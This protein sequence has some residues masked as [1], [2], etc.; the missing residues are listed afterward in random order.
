MLSYSQTY[1]AQSSTNSNG[2]RGTVRWMAIELLD[3]ENNTRHTKFSD[4]WALGMTVYVSKLYADPISR[5]FLSA[6]V[7][8]SFWLSSILS[9]A[10]RTTSYYRDIERKDS[11]SSRCLSRLVSSISITL[12]NLRNLLERGGR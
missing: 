9:S 8:A 5:L 12:A 6:S 10:K 1:G 4:I 2:A 3:I 7:G 11:S